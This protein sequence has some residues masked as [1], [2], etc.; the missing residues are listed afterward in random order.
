MSLW[1]EFVLLL[2]LCKFLYLRCIPLDTNL[3]NEISDE[4]IFGDEDDEED[5]EVGMTDDAIVVTVRLLNKK[6]KKNTETK[7]KIVPSKPVTALLS[8][9]IRIA[10]K[11]NFISSTD[12]SVQIVFQFDGTVLNKQKNKTCEQLEIEDGDLVDA[13]LP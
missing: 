9:F 4:F 3:K 7:L 5:D 1:Y 10:Q 6:T 2:K 13:V 12:K 11:K 8:G